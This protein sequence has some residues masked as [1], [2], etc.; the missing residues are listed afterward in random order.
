ML[1]LKKTNISAVQMALM[2]YPV[3]L[4]T[5]F[6]SM[7]TI[8]SLFTNNDLWLTPV[9]ALFT[10]SLAL[11]LAVGLHRLYPGQTVIE[12]SPTIVGAFPGTLVGCYLFLYY[13][14]GTGAIVRQYAEFVTGAF[15]FK[16]PML[17]VISSLVLLSAIAVRGGVELLARCAVIFTPMF[18]L[19][20][21]ILLLLIPDLDAHYLFP[22]LE[23]GIVPVL[24]G[25]VAPEAWV[26]EFFMVSF[27]LPHLA[28]PDKAGKWG[29]ISLTA[30]ILSLLYIDLVTLTLFGPDINNKIYPVL[31]AFRYISLANFFENMEALLLAMWVVGN[32]VKISVFLYA[33]VL[34]LSQTLKLRDY[35]PIVLPL[36]VWVV[37]D[38]IWSMPTFDILSSYL[39]YAAP[40]DILFAN[41]AIPLILFSIAYMKGA[42][43][44]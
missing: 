40:F 12:Y 23:R 43:K 14:R 11:F 41:L 15:L 30:V 10:G 36:A 37:I 2:M 35:R 13:L 26:S 25:A 22:V 34:S 7:P 38:S 16:T 17:I 39:R 27:F 19:P 42:A 9:F 5:A 33:A 6:L 20:F 32:F 24:Q 29:A 1:S 44:S 3:V 18:C 8:T 28:D 21:L 4:A 31:N